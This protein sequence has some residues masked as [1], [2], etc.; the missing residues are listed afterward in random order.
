MDE[1]A[2]PEPSSQTGP[3]GVYVAPSGPIETVFCEIYQEIIAT[4]RIGVTDNFYDMGGDSIAAIQIAILA[5]EHGFQIDANHIFEFQTIRE[6][7]VHA[8]PHEETVVVDDSAPL[9]SLDLGDME[10]IASQISGLK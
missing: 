9:I 7:S 6:L 4:A 2:L 5:G 8:K 3:K 1:R 10:A